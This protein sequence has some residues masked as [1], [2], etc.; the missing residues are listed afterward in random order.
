MK[1]KNIDLMKEL[2]ELT[3]ELS[4]KCDAC[5]DNVNSEIA[6]YCEFVNSI[7]SGNLPDSAYSQIDDEDYLKNLIAIAKQELSK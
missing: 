3:F 1:L 7:E 2:D 4:E 6:K 5:E